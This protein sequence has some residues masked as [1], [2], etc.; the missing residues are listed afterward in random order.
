MALVVRHG[1]LLAT[2]SSG[3]LGN[4]SQGW[5]TIG[6]EVRS[7][8]TCDGENDLWLMGQSPALKAIIAAYQQALHDHKDYRPLFMVLSGKQVEPPALG[9]GADYD[10]AFL[11]MHLVR[12]VPGASCTN[13]PQDI[14]SVNGY[15]HKITFDISTLDED[16]L[17]GPSGGKRALSYEFCILNTVVNKAEVKRLDPTV[18]FFTKSPG[19][20]GCGTHE[21]LCLGST[22]QQDFAII[23]RRLA[24]LPY[25]QRID[26]SFFE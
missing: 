22:H 23:L 17:Y 15:M 21:S 4:V 5:V 3:D 13:D 7:F 2:T 19:R 1:Q 25:V 24:E 12:V 9:F 10:A 11:A 18:A 16:G 6:H 14:D 26:Q 8:K 20:I